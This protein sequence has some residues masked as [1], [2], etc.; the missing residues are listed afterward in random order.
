MREPALPTAEEVAELVQSAL[1]GTGLL[2]APGPRSPASVVV[3]EQL[4]QSLGNPDE[5]ND[6]VLA[7]FARSDQPF[8]ARQ[9]ARSH[10]PSWRPLLS[11]PWVTRDKSFHR[12][13]KARIGRIFLIVETPLL[14]LDRQL[15]FLRLQQGKCTGVEAGEFE[16]FEYLARRAGD[17]WRVDPL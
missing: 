10:R 11:A 3:Y 12:L 13:T 17:G 9:I 7:H 2:G 15:A 16:D 8:L 5:D 4:G 14:S 6:A 1:P